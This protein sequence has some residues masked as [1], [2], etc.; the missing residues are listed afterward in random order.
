MNMRFDSD[1]LSTACFTGHREQRLPRDFDE[2]LIRK[3][4]LDAIDDG[5]LTFWN[6]GATG[7][8]TLAAEAVLELRQ[9]H[10]EIELHMAIPCPNHDKM[11]TPEQ[12]ER[13][14]YIMEHAD[15]MVLVNPE[16]T[17]GCMERRNRYMVERSSRVIA[18]WDGERSGGTWQTVNMAEREGL[19]VVVVH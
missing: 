2:G 10:P 8:D 14:R 5:Y 6:G 19:E 18:I 1:R 15:G 7:A 17:A 9:D 13:L 3:A 4:I 11:W 12:R 16:Y